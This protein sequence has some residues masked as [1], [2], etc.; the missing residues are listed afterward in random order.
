MLKH[1]I[2]LLQLNKR[3]ETQ[4]VNKGLTSVEDIA[5]FFPRRY[6]D[7]RK[8]TPVKDVALGNSYALAG[9]VIK[10]T[11]GS[12]RNVATIQED[13]QTIPGYRAKFEVIWFG[14]DYYFKQLVMG[15]RYI[16]CGRVSAFRGLSQIVSPLVF[17][18]DPNKVCRILP[19]YPKIKGMSADY[20]NTQI[21]SAIGFLRTNERVGEKELYAD[22][23]RLMP[24]FDAIQELHQP[25]GNNRFRRAQE[26][27]AYESIY[28]FYA[29]LKRKD[30]YLVGKEAQT[31]QKDKLTQAVIKALPFP[32]TAD[33]QATIDT[34][35]REA[36]AG[37][38]LHSL[39][40]G[41]VGCGKTMIA[42]LSA[43]F[44]WENGFQTI[45]MA[46]TLVLAQQHFFEIMNYASRLGISIGLLTTDTSK[47]ERNK[48]L[49]EFSSGSL[50]ILIGT[51][52]VLSDDI[53]PHNLGLT[54]ID[55]EHKFG[56]QQKGK[57]EEYDKAGVHHISMT[58]TPIPRSIAMAV[59]SNELAILPIR[60][61]PAGRKP[62]QTSQCFTPDEVFEKMYEEI[63][64]G[65][66]GYLICP[67]IEDSVSDQFQ[68]VMSIASVKKLAED[69]FGKTV[70]NVRIGVIS[71]DMKQ[72]DILATVQ[73]FANKDFDI[74][75][76]T[77]IVEVGVNV[78]NATAIGIMSAD[79]FGLAA[80]HQLRG[81]VGRSS[82]QGYCYLCSSV[83][84]E[85]L[86]I[87]CQTT[88]GFLIAEEDMRLR[89]PGDLTGDAQSGASEIIDLIIKRPNLTKAIK[90]KIFGTNSQISTS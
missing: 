22:K 43:I 51:H 89:G 13:E 53:V 19:I 49:K 65:H 17:G 15:E 72:K 10:L 77:T 48:I 23:L 82:D 87:L 41:D 73:R 75:I 85:R 47:K 66:Q 11:A 84:T 25:T 12:Q 64:K 1:P 59:Y 54:I 50:S 6:V 45:L 81:R 69:Y 76:S 56:V 24:K 83:R 27:M 62:I 44:M 63:K 4:F 35:I 86:D 8:I 3:K 34:I 37:R 57:L 55:E 29:D 40:S 14:T 88:D 78:P 42:V 74:L 71:G 80:L 70:N 38:R 9:T 52:A 32:L 28:D 90:D 21:K 31:A 39:V 33:Q 68:N 67:F 60:T 30:L 58:A 7:F 16:F 26:R 20:L 36:K 79:R 18:Q 46:P 61:M 5:Y 2:E